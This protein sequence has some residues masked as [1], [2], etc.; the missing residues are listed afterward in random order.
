MSHY[1]T[2]TE[3]SVFMFRRDFN[4]FDSIF[5]S[6]K[7]DLNY[8]SK[9][10]PLKIGVKHFTIHTTGTSYSQNVSYKSQVNKLYIKIRIK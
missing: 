10:S 3:S 8:N 9:N 2:P 4:Y 5:V 7:I 1:F 6:Y